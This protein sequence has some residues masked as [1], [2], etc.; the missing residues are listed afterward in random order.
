MWYEA[1]MEYL[2]KSQVLGVPRNL[3]ILKCEHT[4]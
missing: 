4:L 1:V 3:D 2:D